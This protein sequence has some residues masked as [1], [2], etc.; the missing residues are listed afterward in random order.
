MEYFILL[1]N[2]QGKLYMM[3][4]L[5]SSHIC[6]LFTV[7]RIESSGMLCHVALV[8]TDVSEKLSASIIRVAKIGELGKTL[9]VT[10]NRRTLRRNTECSLCSSPILVILMMEVIRSSET[11]VLTRVT[12]YNIP[13]GGILHS[14]SRENL[15]SYI[16]YGLSRFLGANRTEALRFCSVTYHLSRIL[17]Y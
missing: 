1:N 3:Q 10:S 8:R 2:V 11:S 4:L 13:E 9:A 6:I 17:E 5:C 14:Q 12:R 7:W 15:K 16:V